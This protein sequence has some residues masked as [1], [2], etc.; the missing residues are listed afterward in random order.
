MN[1]P[2]PA[3]ERSRVRRHPERGSHDRALVHAILDEALVC[4]VGLIV[5]GRPLVIPMAYGREGDRLFLHGAVASRLLRSLAGGVEACV[6]VTLLDG[7]VL[8][9]STFSSSLN[10]RSVV[11]FGRASRVEGE[12]ERRRALELIVEHLIP[13]RTAEARSANPAELGATEVVE[14]AI[15][16]ATAKVRSGPPKEPEDDLALP[17]WAGV[18]PATL[19]W[20]APEPAPNL[21]GGIE[22][23]AVVAGYRRPAARRP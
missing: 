4:H 1:T 7:L 13:G 21:R 5:D 11:A 16:E 22:A 8:A 18:I 3:S 20:G 12:A 14:F 6:T 15:E 23:S 9:R 10:Y 19:A 17:V 2:F